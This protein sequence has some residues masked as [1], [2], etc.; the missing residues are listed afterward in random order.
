M[1]EFEFPVPF[2]YFC[3]PQYRPVDNSF[4]YLWL[5]HLEISSGLRLLLL[6]KNC[7][8]CSKTVD[9]VSQSLAEVINRQCPQGSVVKFL[10]VYL[11]CQRESCKQNASARSIL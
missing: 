1:G 11:N 8:I 7:H 9:N 4:F 6:I 2:S 10:H 3:N 5:H